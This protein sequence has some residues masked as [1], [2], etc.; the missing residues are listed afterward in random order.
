MSSRDPMTSPSRNDHEKSDFRHSNQLPLIGT[1]SVRDWAI[2]SWLVV[3]VGV[4]E[5]LRFAI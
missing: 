1:M 5:C 3:C 2:H 4:H